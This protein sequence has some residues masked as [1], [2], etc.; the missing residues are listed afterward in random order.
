MIKLEHGDCLKLMKNIPTGSVD[1]ILCDPPYGTIKGMTLDGWGNGNKWDNQLPIKAMFKQYERILREQGL[2]IIFSEEPFTSKLRTKNYYN[3]NFIY[4]LVWIKNN[5][6]NGFIAHKAPVHMFED[7]SVF[8]KKYDRQNKNPLRQYS[9][10]IKNYEHKSASKICQD[11]NNRKLDHFLRSKSMQFSLPIKSAYKNMVKKYH[12]K[13]K[14]WYIPYNQMKLLNKEY[15]AT[16]NLIGN[17]NHISDVFKCAKDYPRYPPTQKP[18]KLLKEL[19]RIYTNKNNLVL[20]NCMGSGSTGVACK[21]LH[22][23]F[24]GMEL[25]DHYFKIAKKRITNVKL[26]Q[27]VTE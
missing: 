19:I 12:L 1:L 4:P 15:Q 8:R 26:K 24:I 7:L 14:S 21:Q 27:L 25:N 10:H 2:A 13:N 5:Y 18:V 16:F 22:R 20:D 23:N 9:Q 11:F 3:L 6:A 17:Y